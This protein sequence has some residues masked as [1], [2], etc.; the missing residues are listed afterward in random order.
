MAFIGDAVHTLYVRKF[1]L[2]KDATVNFYNSI[3]SHLCNAVFQASVFDKLELTDEEKEIAR[4]ARNT[5]NNNIPKNASIEQYK[6]ATCLE[7]VIGYLYLTNSIV[8]LEQI[9][10]LCVEE[11]NDYIR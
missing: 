8:R 2:T 5:K 10:K 7:A 11:N 6:K 1:V 9:L 3:C 4:R